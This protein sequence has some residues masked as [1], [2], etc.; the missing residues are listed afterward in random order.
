VNLR[1][2]L[3]RLERSG[4]LAPRSCQAVVY[5]AEGRIVWALI[6]SRWEPVTDPAALPPRTRPVKAYIGIDPTRV[7]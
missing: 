3:A 2:R 7:C 1:T 6:D 4:R 5:N